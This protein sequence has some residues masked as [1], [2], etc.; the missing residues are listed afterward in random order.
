[1]IVFVFRQEL[2]RYFVAAAMPFSGIFLPQR[3]I[4]GLPQRYAKVF[5]QRNTK[6]LPLSNTKVFSQ[7]NTKGWWTEI[8]YRSAS[9]RL[10]AVLSATVRRS[11]SLRRSYQGLWPAN[12][13]AAPVRCFHLTVLL[14]A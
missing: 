4:K 13:T 6:G 7:R 8:P 5:S 2:L 11:V 3:N 1:M 9:L 10:S 12:A 14:R